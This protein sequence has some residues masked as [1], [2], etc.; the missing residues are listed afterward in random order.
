MLSLF[1]S[2]TLTGL[3]YG[4]QTPTM[5]YSTWNYFP[6]K[7]ID[8]KTCYDFADEMVKAGLVDAG[9]RVFIVDEPCFIGRDSTGQLVQNSTTWPNGLKAFSTYLKDRNMTL[10][11]YTDAGDKTCQGCPGSQGHEK[12]DMATFKSW[13]IEY[14]KVDRC[15]GV[16]SP[17]MR[18][19][20][21]HTF[22][23]YDTPGMQ[24]SMILA[25]TDNCWVWGNQSSVSC[26]TTGDIHYSASSMYSNIENQEKVPGIETFAGPGFFNDLDMLMIGTNSSPSGTQT[27]TLNES[28]IQMSVW[29]ALKSPLLASNNVKIVPEEY[30]K[31]LLNKEAIDINQDPL[32]IQAKR[33]SW[34]AEANPNPRPRVSFQY[35]IGDLMQDWQYSST[36]KTLYSNSSKLCLATDGKDVSLG[37]CTSKPASNNT[38]V[39]ESNNKISLESDPSLCL[40]GSMGPGYSSVIVGPCNSPDPVVQKL[41]TWT[42]KGSTIAANLL[43]YP[44]CLTS[45]PLPDSVIDMY[46]GPLSPARWGGSSAF[47]LVVVNFQ[48]TPVK[49]VFDFSQL[50]GY[51]P[52]TPVKIRNTWEAKDI[53][54]FTNTYE[55]EIQPVN[56]LMLVLTF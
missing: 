42:A 30:L 12:Q 19:N 6:Y 36:F 56:A 35:C 24:V 10:G 39:F 31:I 5:G 46:L 48:K 25:G 50:A 4:A 33:I 40:Q 41:Q 16:D 17:T 53:G 1:T 44:T 2:A 54:T 52:N 38:W 32:A 23:L 47:V 18:D 20:L 13:G 22:S 34:S 21:P 3:G 8:E 7:G 49:K 15:F 29:S 14:V 9:Y 45:T 37:G 27:L 51:K 43:E 11:I 55:I 28:I 26:R